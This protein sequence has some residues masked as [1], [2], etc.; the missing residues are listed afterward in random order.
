[1]ET[2][3]VSYKFNQDHPNLIYVLKTEQGCLKI[4]DIKFILDDTF[5]AGTYEVL[6][7]EVTPAID[8]KMEDVKIDIIITDPVLEAE[9]LAAE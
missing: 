7:K 4:S 2:K 3:W 5:N 8:N 6:I 9:K 1:M